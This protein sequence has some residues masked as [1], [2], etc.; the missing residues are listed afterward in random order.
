MNDKFEKV[1]DK[2]T[3]PESLKKETLAMMERE[4]DSHKAGAGR[5]SLI[6]G[7]GFAAVALC[8]AALCFVLLKPAGGIYV[9]DMAEG[10]Y[11]DEVEL[12]DGVIHFV[13]NRVA[14]S[15]SPNA[16]NAAIGQ[17]QDLKEENKAD[18]MIE[19]ITVKSGGTITFRRAAALSLPE[20]AEDNWSYIGEQ[21]IYVT[22]LK[23]EKIRYQAAFE[24]EG[25][26]YEII[27]V[28][29]TQKEF[30]DYLY[31]KIK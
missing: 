22:V 24:L 26:S 13:S 21:P 1:Y 20:M 11:Y 8:V 31:D 19:E 18:A 12:K 25:K 28:G 30:I 16:G 27:G 15:I 14:I 4:N 29:V 2:I 10:V 3:A 7:T 6:F 9:T 5:R 23:T 17:E